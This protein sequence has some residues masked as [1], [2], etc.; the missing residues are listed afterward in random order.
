MLTLEY[1]NTITTDSSR[2]L[3]RSLQPGNEPAA[4]SIVFSS[5][6]RGRLLWPSKIG[7]P[8]SDLAVHYSFDCITL[9]DL[10]ISS[11]RYR[12]VEYENVNLYSKKI[13]EGR[14]KLGR[15]GKNA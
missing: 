15:P 4:A 3:V 1:R 7:V 10:N 2:I 6:Q 11:G 14:T 8:F 13:P 5:A 12:I 9:Q